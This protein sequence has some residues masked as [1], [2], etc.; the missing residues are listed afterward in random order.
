MKRK[1]SYFGDKNYLIKNILHVLIFYGLN[2][3]VYLFYL[4]F[5]TNKIV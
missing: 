5:P 3:I 2:F 4:N 1:W